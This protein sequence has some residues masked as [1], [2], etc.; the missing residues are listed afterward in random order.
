MKARGNFERLS[1]NM[2]LT[3]RR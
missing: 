2:N 1:P 3:W